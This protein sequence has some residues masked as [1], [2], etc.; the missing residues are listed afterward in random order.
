MSQYVSGRKGRRGFTLVE[1]A[2]VIVIIG[3]L[4]SFGVP[5]FMKSVE[6]SKAA[7]A[8][9]F[10]S[11]VRSSQERYQAREGKY[12]SVFSDLDLQWKVDG[13]GNPVLKYFTLGSMTADETTWT[14]TLTRAAGASGY[15]G[16]TV[17]FNQNGYDPTST[18]NNFPSINPMSTGGGTD[19]SGGGSGGSGS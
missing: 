18:I 13:S 10:L 9:N 15:A 8:F 6:R 16:Y 14:L 3:V 7:E 12:A 2:V 4:A 19:G 17:I 1:L 5:Q 11:A